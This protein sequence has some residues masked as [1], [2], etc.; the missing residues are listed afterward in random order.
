M[1]LLADERGRYYSSYALWVEFSIKAQPAYREVN[2]G[3]LT[4]ADA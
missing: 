1:S 3:L 2:Y 4:A